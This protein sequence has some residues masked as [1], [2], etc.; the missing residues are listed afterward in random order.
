MKDRERIFE[1]RKNL[2]DDWRYRGLSW[3]EITYKYR[4]SKR[5][6]YKLRMRFLLEGYEGLR[7]RVRNNSN[8][9][10]RASWQERLKIL[11][12]VYYNP[13]HGPRRIA[14]EDPSIGL[15]PTTVW[16]VLKQEDL[17]T[18]AKR[19]LWAQAQGRRILT[20]KEKQLILA[21]NRHI[22]SRSPGELLGIDSFCV[23]VANLGR[24]WQYTACDTYSSY[25]FAR[26]YLEKTSDTAIDFMVNHVLS[27]SPYGKIRRVLTDQGTEF[28][29]ARFKDTESAFSFALRLQSI[30][31]SVT[32]VA[33]PWTNGYVERLN[34]TIWQEFYQ[35]RLDKEYTICDELNKDLDAYMR[36]YNFKRVHSGYKLVEGGYRFP[37]HAFFDT[38]EKDKIIEL[39]Y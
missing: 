21:K 30:R 32:K 17:N 12:Y 4:V 20:K 16:S 18:R 6:F 29:N 26:V 38:R 23:S 28:Y 33:H 7:D 39:K 15:S 5:W 25:G 1:L 37:G 14:F 19:R 2:I 3:Q 31:H 27:R 22:E 35:C 8:R 9:P 34:Q 10:Y 36:Y 13:T 11:D 24:V